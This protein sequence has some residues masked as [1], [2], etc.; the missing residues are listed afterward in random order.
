MAFTFLAANAYLT[1]T[2]FVDNDK[3]KL[4]KEVTT[5]AKDKK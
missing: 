4:A 1:G 3:F 2:S 5:F